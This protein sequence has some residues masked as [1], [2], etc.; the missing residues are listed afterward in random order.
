[1]KVAVIGA[2]TMGSGIAQ[3]CAIA[4]HEV[5]VVDSDPSKGDPALQAMR[6]S[7]EKLAA[8]DKL[9]G[10]QPNDVLG[11]VSTG[12]SIAAACDGVG[13]VIETVVERLDV[14]HEVFREVLASAP[15]DALLGSNTSQLSITK[16]GSVLGDQAARLVGMHF[17]NPPV[18]MRL[19]ELVVGLQSSEE[20]VERAEEFARGLGKETVVCR[21]DSPG[22]MTSRVSAIVRME[23]LKMLEEG[24]GTPADI[25]KALRLGLN[26]PMGPLELGDFNGLDTYL[27]ALEALEVAHGERFRPTVTLRNLV[28]AGRLGRKTGWGIYRYGADGSKVDENN[29]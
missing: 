1:V 3:V 29:A 2:G 27:H 6:A 17:F 18:L 5:R 28:A 7:L 9:G 15:N 16:I 12:T 11:R 4:G 19:V 26:F 14:K 10:E 8:K 25:D 21:K 13:T 23:C 22:F 24:V 20:S